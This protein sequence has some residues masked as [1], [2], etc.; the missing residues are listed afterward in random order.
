M[1]L[2]QITFNLGALDDAANSGKNYVS[3]QV[4]EV[5]NIDDT[6]AD[7][8][9]DSAGTIPIDQSGIQN[10]SNS[11]GECK[12]FIDKGFYNIK[13]GGKARQLNANF[14][15]EFDTVSDAVNAR[16]I[17]LLEGRRV[18]IKERK[19]HFNVMPSVT[20]N[21]NG[22]NEILSAANTSFGFAL[23]ET[24]NV[25][26][27]SFG[28][29][30]EGQDYTGAIESWWNY[31]VSPQ[32]GRFPANT[33]EESYFVI[34]GPVGIIESGKYIYSGSGLTL[35]NTQSWM[36]K[37]KGDGSESTQIRIESDS[38][39]IDAENNPTGM[40]IE[41]VHF[42]GGKG[43]Y[44]SRDISV[45]TTR[46]IKFIDNVVSDYSV[47]GFA[48]ECQDEPYTK[49]LRN[50]FDGKDNT[51]TM[52]IA[53]Q[54]LRA[55]SE[56]IGNSFITYRYGIKLG[57]AVIGGND[58]GPTVPM[59]VA[60]NDWFRSGRTP[61]NSWC[62]WI[63]PNQD[64]FQNA[65]R[66]L[67]FNNNKFGNENL[68]PGD[69]QV[70]IA[71]EAAGSSVASRFHNQAVAGGYVSGVVFHKNSVGSE[72][73][74]YTAPFIYSYTGKLF[75][76]DINDVYDNN[77]PSNIVEY[78][79]LVSL[80]SLEQ[81]SRTNIINLSQALAA[82]EGETVKISNLYEGNF[83]VVDP[84]G[85]YQGQVGSNINNQIGEYV[86]YLDIL[87]ETV[88]SGW[89]VG[90]ATK[91]AIDN[92]AGKINEAVEVT[93]SNSSG[94][95]VGDVDCSSAQIGARTW[96]DLDIKQGAS[97]PVEQVT[98]SVASSG[99]RVDVSRTF[100]LSSE[101][102][103]VRIP[104]SVRDNGAY[105]VR[106]TSPLSGAGDTFSVGNAKVYQNINPINGGDL[107]CESL[108]GQEWNSGHIVI[109]DYHIFPDPSGVLRIKN[110][111]PAN[112]LDGTVIGSQS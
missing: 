3:G 72:W 79:P 103:R 43:A 107:R 45:S 101:W 26:L 41:G 60:N 75:N 74:G 85:Y 105:F 86:N 9:A 78:D 95:L 14:S 7:I 8:F 67:W 97:S 68:Q 76:T 65:G 23:E 69:S 33:G 21:P 82:Q 80:A 55:G 49:I 92:S 106:V 70:L 83:V 16:F 112:S 11:D 102:R 100:K 5:F 96:I 10:I 4:F 64:T 89:S 62:V 24:K 81:G 38:F 20:M 93:M 34:K 18:Y 90:D 66:A 1:A 44:I 50:Q 22:Y 53:L 58:K 31:I 59:V 47:C 42:S 25:T 88:T 15:F 17:S 61:T 54:G 51:E 77:M 30:G 63:V 73:D 39:F 48:S 91:S 109:G 12:F 87:N 36:F 84:L 32:V 56:I 40:H 110:G 29:L 71:L 46:L 13:S 108:T 94:R 35:D 19:A 28:A 52:C 6:Y 104:W 98:V 111:A 57:T 99:G 27:R 37:I 2:E